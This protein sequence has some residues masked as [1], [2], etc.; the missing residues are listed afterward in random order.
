RGQAV[1]VQLPE[2]ERPVIDTCG[3]G[4][5]GTGTFNV[6][7]TAA[8]VVAGAGVHVAKHGNRA[9]SSQTGS[10]DLLQALG[11]EITSTPEDVAHQVAHIGFGFMLA[12]AYHPAM[13]FVMP[14]RR[15]IGTPTV[16]NILGPLSNPAFVRRQVI[17]VRDRATARLMA[18][19]LA[20]LGSERILM[21]TSSEGADELTLSGPNHVVDFDGTSGEMR[22][23]TID[24]ADLDFA[25]A[26]LDTI[27]G[28]DAQTNAAI[29]IRILAGEPGPYRDTVLLNAAAGLVASG[30]AIDIRTGIG[31][32]ATAIDSGAAANVVKQYVE[33]SQS[34]AIGHTSSS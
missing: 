19:A 8:F 25:N 23:Y 6:S 18:S 30:L 27:R 12:P 24:A 13:R 9:A 34:V 14:V 11:A 28:G 17:G 2:L 4:G 32:A 22:E 33:V 20:G 29:T 7:T 31:L 10:A 26:T 15:T 3:T 5:D 1:R 21:V 16:F